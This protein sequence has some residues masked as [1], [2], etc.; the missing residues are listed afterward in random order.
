MWTVYYSMVVRACEIQGQWEEGGLPYRHALATG[1]D[2][3]A[4][5]VF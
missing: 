1:R 3:Q 2:V 5:P 4:K